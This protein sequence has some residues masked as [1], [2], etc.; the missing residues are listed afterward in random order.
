MDKLKKYGEEPYRVAV[1]HGGPGAGGEMAPVAEELSKKYGVIEPIQT[2]M[3]VKGQTDEL[4]DQLID[5]ADFPITIIGYSWGAWLSYI[6]AATYP[7]LIKKLILVSSGPFEDSYVKGIRDTRFSRLE[8]KDQDEVNFLLKAL[9]KPIVRDKNKVFARIGKLMARADNFEPVD[10][11]PQGLI[12]RA[13]IY[14]NVWREA[15][16]MRKS[17]ALL[18]FADKIKCPVIAIHGDYD[19]HPAEGVEKPL[20]AAI[21]N[22]KLILL[23]NCGHVPWMEK[24]AKDKFFKALKKEI[25]GDNDK[26]QDLF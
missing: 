21:K 15:D 25:S 23:K 17:G 4:K 2:A 22:F 7:K 8:Q 6:F 19:P 3:S 9:D 18:K 20:S 10:E 12:I 11:E 16:K 14:R 24:Q 5:S 26:Q 1:I 13:D